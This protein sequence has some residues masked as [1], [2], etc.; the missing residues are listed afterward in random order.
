MAGEWHPCHSRLIQVSARS[1][2]NLMGLRS[3]PRR[4]DLA[5][6]GLPRQ[7]E[8][9]RFCSRCH[10][11]SPRPPEH[12]P[13]RS[14]DL[15]RRSRTG[16]AGD[17]DARPRAGRSP[18]GSTRPGCAGQSLRGGLSLIAGGLVSVSIRSRS[19]RW[20]V[21]R[22]RQLP[23]N[24]SRGTSR[25]R[26][27][28]RSGVHQLPTATHPRTRSTPQSAGRARPRL[29]LDVRWQFLDLLQEAA[30]FAPRSGSI[31]PGSRGRNAIH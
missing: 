16:H 8:P 11:R 30:A 10:S 2:R 22:P 25:R 6:V 12:P 1:G 31:A 29:S 21:L 23:Q 15:H 3:A 5:R 27:S 26:P 13:R 7:H 24:S 9:G 18:T 20:Q 14:K 4:R 28:S 17:R 19:P